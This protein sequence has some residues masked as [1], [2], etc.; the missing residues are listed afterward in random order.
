MPLPNHTINF[1]EFL[2]SFR[3]GQLLHEA[4]EHL[5]K[6][7]SAMAETGGDG[8][9]TIKLPFKRNKAGQI[10]CTPKISSK[11]P[12]RQMGTG[13]YFA[14]DEGRLSRRDPNQMDIEDEI[15]RRRPAAA[16]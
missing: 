9:I 5:E 12:H 10:E 13:I 3:R 6:V 15:E 8:E 7:I 14:D 2:Q 4:D 11:T 1:L 16:E